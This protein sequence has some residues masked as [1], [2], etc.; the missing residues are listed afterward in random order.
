MD[1]ESPSPSLA[2]TPAVAEPVPEADAPTPALTPRLGI[3]TFRSLRH[4]NYRLYFIGQLVSLTG[5]WL[6][7]TALMALAFQ[8]THQS[9]W[10][11]W[12][13]A[14]QILPTFLLGAV[15]GSLADRWP[16]RRLILATQSGLLILALLLMFVAVNN[17][18]PWQLLAVTA[19]AGVVQAIDVPARMAFVM[20]LVSREDLIN[21]V[22]LNSV[23]FNVARAVGPWVAARLLFQ[24]GPEICFL[25]NALSYVAVLWALVLMDVPDVVRHHEQPRAWQALVAGFRDLTERPALLFLVLAA[26]VV[27]LCGWPTQALLPAL[28]ANRLG[29]PIEGYGDMLSAT[30]LGAL[31]AGLTVAT[32]GSWER[33]KHFL[34]LGIAIVSLALIGLSEAETLPLAVGACALL[35]FGLI[36]FLSTGQATV[37]LSTDVHNRGR[38]LG[39]WAM[40]LSGAVPLGNL[41]VGAAADHW[42]VPPVLLVQGLVCGGAGLGLFLLYRFWR[43]TPESTT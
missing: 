17:P 41:I 43:S 18:V 16:K 13:S 23:I 39:I 12:I 28:A 26:S 35:G 19:A 21:A 6:Q 36:L 29:S 3:A 24:L 33:R 15:G 27:A 1:D 20:D 14:A 8:L 31:A 42:T 4:R 34:G 5:T 38:L 40:T 11:A 9:R 10:P 37:Q 32:F 2:E 25:V 30:G 22:A 7:T